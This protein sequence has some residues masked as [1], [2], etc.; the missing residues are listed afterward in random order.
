MRADQDGDLGVFAIELLAKHLTTLSNIHRVTDHSVVESLRR[1]YIADD[2]WPRMNADVQPYRSFSAY[3][4]RRVLLP[5]R[6]KNR[7]RGEEG[8]VSV[9][10]ILIRRIP[11]CHHR[12]ANEFV[13]GAAFGLD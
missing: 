3:Q 5:N 13:D 8:V 11:E 2:R 6:C 9:M 7:K 10:V 12:V 4:A 1:A